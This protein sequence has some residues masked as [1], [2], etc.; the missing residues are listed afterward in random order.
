MNE[1]LIKRAAKEAKRQARLV[2][3][4]IDQDRA[5]HEEK[6]ARRAAKEAQRQ[7]MLNGMPEPTAPV[8][9][10]SIDC[11][12]VIHGNGYDWT[13]VERLYNMLSRHINR[14]IR[15]HVYTEHDRSV[16]P[17]MIKHVLEEWTNVSGRKK[18]WWYKMQ[19][20]NPIHHRGPLLYF[21]LDT[22]IVD[23][24]DWV[25]NLSLDYMWTI[26]DYRYLWKPQFEGINSSMMYWNTTRF[27]DVW[28]R[29][30]NQG[31]DTAR[32][33]YQ[34]D[35]DYLTAAVERS[36]RK[37]FDLDRVISWRWEA[38]NGGMNW[39]NRSYR[40]PG[41]GTILQPRNS[42]LIFHGDPKP[43]EINDPLVSKHWQ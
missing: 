33:Y 28:Q 23:N 9:S 8:D 17:H 2:T 20:F 40:H 26:R 29:F 15:F 1:K 30:S 12:C 5:R 37:F 4:D 14:Q 27:A 35:Q 34:G 3:T 25:L 43:N 18:S 21:D 10:N 16:P 22:V 41:R 31:I 39:K 42:V 7:S 38:F 19:L 36:R 32:S 24:I 13:Y 11:A 6:M